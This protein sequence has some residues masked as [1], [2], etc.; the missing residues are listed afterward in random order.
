VFESV[1]AVWI[2]VAALAAPVVAGLLVLSAVLERPSPIR[3]RH[4][5][6]AAG[7]RLNALYGH[8]RRFEAFRFVV[9]MVARSAPIGLFAVLER[10]LRPMLVPAAPWLAGGLVLLL[11][12]IAEWLSR[13]LVADH[14]EAAL[15]RWTWPLRLVAVL[16]APLV[17]VLAT[18][19]RVSTTDGEEEAADEDDEVSANELEAFIDVG[20]RE[21]ILEPEEEELVK[22]I[23]DFGD[24][25]VHQVM[26]P[27]VDIVAASIDTPLE[28]LA[29]R[30]FE[31]KHARL[32][33]FRESIDQIVAILYLRDLFEALHNGG[34]AEAAALAKPP[35]FIPESKP[36]R[37]LL[38]ELQTLHQ[39]MAIVVDE[40]GGAAGLVTVE[41]L[42]E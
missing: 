18:A 11:V 42:V 39:Q 34:A 2:W 31:C 26:T 4:W 9:A 1:A 6:E 22:S 23:V 40:Y 27:R 37:A 25:L 8:Q 3:L 14:A 10:G 29:E 12:A 17:V 32:P 38:S 35:L 5:A 24:T 21:G 36:I 30:F 28:A 41:D 13:F 15:E 19:A 33:L 20:R 16:S 7:P